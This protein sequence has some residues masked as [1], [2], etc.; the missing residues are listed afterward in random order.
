MVLTVGWS[1]GVEESRLVGIRILSLRE[2]AG[3]IFSLIP[4]LWGI[5]LPSGAA[6]RWT[7]SK[8]TNLSNYEWAKKRGSLQVQALPDGASLDDV[9][10]HLISR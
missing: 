1:A 9:T 4:P 3:A 5:R 2:G 10:G 7:C 6:R 8:T